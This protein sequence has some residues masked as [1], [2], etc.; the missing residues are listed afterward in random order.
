[1]R[2]DEEVSSEKQEGDSQ[3]PP[4]E[5]P[6]DDEILSNEEEDD[7]HITLQIGQTMKIF[8][9]KSKNGLN[10]LHRTVKSST[11]KYAC[12]REPEP[13]AK[14]TKKSPKSQFLSVSYLTRGTLSTM[15]SAR[16]QDLN[17]SEMTFSRQNISELYMQKADQI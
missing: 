15:T 10:V 5:I 12:N 7:D 4:Q 11:V 16:V 17:L 13:S 8:C 2:N 6:R 14:S 1:M 3:F 9:L